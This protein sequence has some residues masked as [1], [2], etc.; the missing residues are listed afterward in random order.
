M[1]IIFGFIRQLLKNKKIKKWG[2][3]CNFPIKA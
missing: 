1:P 2:N 3:L